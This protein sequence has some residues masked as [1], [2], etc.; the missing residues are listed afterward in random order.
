[1]P[2]IGSRTRDR[3]TLMEPAKGKRRQPRLCSYATYL[4]LAGDAPDKF[5]T[6][7]K[8]PLAAEGG[9]CSGAGRERTRSHNR[10][11]IAR[12][13]ENGVTGVAADHQS[14]SREAQARISI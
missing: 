14:I 6:P 4:S 12:V 1:M 2:E 5:P 11:G 13:H 7:D 9:R 10:A 8:H 3:S